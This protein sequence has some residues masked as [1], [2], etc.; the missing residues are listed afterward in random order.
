MNPA[1][2]DNPQE[3]CITQS[4]CCKAL[5][6][7]A[8]ACVSGADLEAML[9]A[10]AGSVAGFCGGGSCQIWV[11]DADE[12]EATLAAAVNPGPEALGKVRI[13][14]PEPPADGSQDAAAW[15]GQ[16]I[17][18]N[19]AYLEGLQPHETE[20]TIVPLRADG[21][22]VGFLV[23]I[24]RR[25]A[26]ER[27]RGFAWRAGAI[28]GPA[29]RR[30]REFETIQQKAS[31][32]SAISELSKTVSSSRYL[33]DVLNLVVTMTAQALRFEACSI[34]L[35]DPRTG[36]LTLKATSST[37]RQDVRRAADTVERCLSAQAM[38]QK[39]PI[40]VSDSRE[41]CG[42]PDCCLA[43]T[44]LLG[45]YICHPLRSGDR[46]IGAFCGY[47]AD[48]HTFTD[49]ELDLLAAVTGQ[50]ALAIE[51]SRLI[52]QSAIVQEMHH[53]VKNNLQTIASL[54]RLQLRHAENETVER[55]LQESISRIQSIAAVHEIL[56]GEDVGVVSMQEVVR[57]LLK[58]THQMASSPQR[59]ISTAFFGRDVLLPARL[60]TTAALVIN[61][62]IQN[63]IEHGIG[64]RPT[65]RI[66]VRLRD[67]GERIALIVANDGDPPPPDLDVSETDRLGLQIVNTL[68]RGELQGTFTLTRNRLT[69]ATVEFPKPAGSV[70]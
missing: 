47:F 57:A 61:E 48:P 42:A 2:A 45:S 50:A 24:Q 34:I 46:V 23:L 8:A 39:Q 35:S 19:Y 66:E 25:E 64:D 40:L 6:S 32:L 1:S 69:T 12:G 43:E 13:G 53:R 28:V 31:Q 68:V 49:E 62:L 16:S 36:D 17:L 22:V 3:I 56:A 44:D 10:V 4:E 9:D 15:L 70:A 5:C 51:N 11:F 58:E 30:L 26:F 65:G 54:L 55:A 14:L 63:A 59:K 60:A 52:V 21:T 7:I 27:C 38:A 67:D 18:E 20:R 33:E 29:V 37:S 41:G